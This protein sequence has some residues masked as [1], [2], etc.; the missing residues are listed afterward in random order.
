MMVVRG[1]PSSPSW[2]VP[3]LVMVR[4]TLSSHYGVYPIQ[5][6]WGYQ[7]T[8]MMGGYGLVGGVMSFSHDGGGG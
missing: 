1:T 6:W 5:S 8:P 7:S 4:G 3:H 2:G